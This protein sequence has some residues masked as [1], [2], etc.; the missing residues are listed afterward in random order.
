LADAVQDTTEG[1]GVDVVLELTGSPDSFET[2]LPLVR[3]G[4]TAVLV[5]SVFPSRPV[6]VLLEQLARRC[7]TLRG[8]H[9]YAPK[10]LAAALLFLAQHSEYPFSQLVA[11]WQA[12]AA[13]NA[14]LATPLRP[15]EL[16]IGI[17]P[18]ISAD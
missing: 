11:P 10:H 15:N 1:H 6:P 9:N 5:G 7:L 3:I 18:G 4:G 2:A 17:R 16:R 8:I 13:V 12:L 14:A